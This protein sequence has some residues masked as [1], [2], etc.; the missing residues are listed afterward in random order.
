MMKKRNYYF[1]KI[2]DSSRR[3]QSLINDLLNFSKQRASLSDFKE[4]DLNVLIKE[5]IE[6][7]G[8]WD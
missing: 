1:Q 7:T 3:M 8:N 4:V 2:I 6:R 5:V